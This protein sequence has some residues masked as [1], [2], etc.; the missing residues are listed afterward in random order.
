MESFFTW[1][2]GDWYDRR[3]LDRL[4]TE[5]IA[6]GLF[7]SVSIRR[8]TGLDENGELPIHLV[9]AEGKHRSVGLEL[10][11]STDEGFGG[12]ASWEHRN[13]GGR[14]GRLTTALRVEEVQQEVDIRFRKPRFLQSPITLLS[15]LQLSEENKDAYEGPVGN[16]AI[17]LDRRIG[18]LWT[19]GASAW[20]EASDLEDYLGKRRFD[21]LGLDLDLR[22]N[23]ANDSLDPDSGWRFDLSLVPYHISGDDDLDVLQGTL[24]LRGYVSLP[25]DWGPVLAGLAKFGA[26]GNQDAEVLPANRRFYAGGGYSIRGYALQSVGPTTEEGQPKG[27]NALAEFGL[28]IRLRFSETLGGV[29]FAEGGNVF[30]DHKPD[31]TRELRWAVG[32][33]IRLFTAA[34]PIRFD[35]GVPID[36]RESDDDFQFYISIGQAF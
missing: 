11:W 10:Y 30:E 19:L 9:L 29:I 33:G 25:G 3:K 17:G 36:P 32:A 7:E 4:R 8:A 15:S 35:L 13:I 24:D 23:S 34:G 20:A 5:L 2:Q 27:G 16:T 14:Q 28:E 21:L 12:E 6:T 31:P 22:R 1:K 26:I 18:Q